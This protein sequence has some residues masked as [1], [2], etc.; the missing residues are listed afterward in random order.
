MEKKD[1]IIYSSPTF[2]NK[3]LEMRKIKELKK[4]KQ[5]TEK[6]SGRKTQHRAKV[7]KQS[8]E[9]TAVQRI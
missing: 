6:H 1:S 9:M 4:K 7:V 8:Q 5:T 2:I 3:L